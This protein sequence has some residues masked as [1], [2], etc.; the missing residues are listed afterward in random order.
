LNR[1]EHVAGLGDAGPVDLLFRLAFDDFGRASAILPATLKVLAHALRFIFF[2][3]TGVCF[4]LGHAD[5][6]QGIQDCPTLHFQ[7]AC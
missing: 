3:R 7:F 4:L 1:L 6:R 2:Q 5:V